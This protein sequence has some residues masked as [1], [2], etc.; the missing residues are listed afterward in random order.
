MEANC[1]WAGQA[2]VKLMVSTATDSSAVRVALG[3]DPGP[4]TNKRPDSTGVTLSNAV[5]KVILREVTPYPSTSSTGQP[6]TAVV[7]VTKL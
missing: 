3:A 4:S 1:I 5:Y 2:R 7:Q 6:K